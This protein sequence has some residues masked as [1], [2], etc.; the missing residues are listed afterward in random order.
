MYLKMP[1]YKIAVIAIW[2]S[3]D[4]DKDTGKEGD[5]DIGWEWEL[6]WY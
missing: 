2:I 4:E 6:G 3:M 5:K 1:K